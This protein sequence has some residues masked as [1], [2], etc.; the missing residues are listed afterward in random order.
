MRKSEAIWIG[1]TVTVV[2]IFVAAPM[3]WG[4]PLSDAPPD[5][6]SNVITDTRMIPM[7]EQHRAMME[8]MRASATAQMMQMMANDPMWQ[9][10]DSGDMIRMMEDAEA[11]MDRM[12]GRP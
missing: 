8:Q 3:V 1:A 4:P 5:L 12:M 9:M 2:G 6:S 11:D 10:L 7:L